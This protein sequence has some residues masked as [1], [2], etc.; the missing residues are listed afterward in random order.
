M[1][2]GTSS[3]RISTT[4]AEAMCSQ[5]PCLRSNQNSSAVCAPYTPGS[6]V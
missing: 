3:A 1:R 4:K 5:K 6:S 2:A